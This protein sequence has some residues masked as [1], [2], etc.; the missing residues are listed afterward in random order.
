MRVACEFRH[1]SW[2]RD[3]VYELLTSRDAAL[4][5]TDRRNR[6]GPLV[7]TATWAFVRM[8]EGTATPRPGY[9]SRALATWA[10]RVATLFGDEADGFVYFNNDHRAC[11]V[12]D[13]AAFR[14]AARRAGLDAGALT[15]T[16]TS[17]P[18][19]S[20]KP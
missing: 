15:T 3:D 9:G 5:L 13:A 11:A 1:P 12:R 4:C 8:H 7:R 18:P 6:H 20:P 10:E 16:R 17:P 2:C 19:A 14:A